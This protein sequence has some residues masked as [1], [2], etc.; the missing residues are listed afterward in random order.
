MVKQAQAGGVGALDEDDYL[1][2]QEN[3]ADV[4]VDDVAGAV[5][6]SYYR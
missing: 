5:D 4:N 6:S 1:L 2:L 3:A